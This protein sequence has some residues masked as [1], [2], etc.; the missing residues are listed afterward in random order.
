MRAND[1]VFNLTGSRV[2]P[3]LV[4]SNEAVAGKRPFANGASL[5]VVA[6]DHGIAR[7]PSTLLAGFVGVAI[8]LLV[9][10]AL[11]NSVKVNS[12]Q[13][14]R[15]F[16]AP[17]AR[18]L[19]HGAGLTDDAQRPALLYPPGM[20]VLYAGVF[21]L[22]DAIGIEEKTG[23]RVLEALLVLVSSM[24]VFLLARWTFDTRTAWIATLLW[25]TYPLFL[26]SVKQPETALPFRIP[27]FAAIWVL[28][29]W[30]EDT[31]NPVRGGAAVGMLLGIS[32]L[33]RPFS[34]GLPAVFAL[35]ALLS[36]N[37]QR[38][39]KVAFAVAVV[40]ANLLTVL[41]WELW[42][43]QASGGKWILLST[44][45]PGSLCDGLT[46]SASRGNV[47]LLPKL[48]TEVKA[49]ITEIA[50]HNLQH[51]LH[52]MGD[53]FHLLA[54]K[55]ADSPVAVAELF[56]IKSA[57]AW[58][59]T[60]SRTRELATLLVQLTYLPIVAL[61]YFRL[62]GSQV[63]RHRNFLVAV[64]GIVLYFWALTTLV[65]S[66]HRYMLPVFPLLLIVAAFGLD[67]LLDKS[68]PE[69]DQ[70]HLESHKQSFTDD[71]G[72]ADKP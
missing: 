52:S 16:Y 17:V 40:G 60:E 59:A 11:P 31:A 14:F 58:F 23:L 12:S 7:I 19:L 46:I 35:L 49:L 38:K 3:K 50:Q 57:R 42:M 61:G 13:D 21:A 48:P 47:P 62:R 37:V 69:F 27:I 67:R 54:R 9:L 24:Q 10:V 66:V 44:N 25:G 32:S 29:H 33:M 64:C 63:A 28:L 15:N 56:L 4:F 22:S 2:T 68:V 70:S 5:R 20:P 65:L 8:H 71:L 45:G 26:W 43:H 34:I 18:N 6:L 39:S 55:V 30:Q 53:I 1:G 36:K 41:P 72:L 51:Q